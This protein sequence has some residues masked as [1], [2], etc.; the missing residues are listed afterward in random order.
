MRFWYT[1]LFAASLVSCVGTVQAQEKKPGKKPD[2]AVAS[3][4]KGEETKSSPLFLRVDREGKEPRALQVAIAKYEIVS[5]PFQGATVDLIGAVHVGTK[6]YYSDLNQRFR[7]YDSVLYELV[8]DPEVNKPNQRAQG[9]FNPISGLQTGMKEALELSFQLDEVDYSPANFVHADMSPGEF[10]EDMKKRNDG[11]IGMFARM[12]GAGIAVQA[13]KK[14][15]QQQAEMMAA[16]VSKDPIRLRRVMAEQFE[17]MEGQMAG[18]ADKD[19]KSTLVTERNRKA[20]EVLQSELEG[21]KRKL[22]VFYGAAHLNDMH[23]R[24]LKDFQAKP[25]STDWVDAWPLR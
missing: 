4:K 9:G 6:Q 15:Q 11:F 17:S 19:G 23:D 1:V 14:G 7:N 21:G 2:S 16:M 18:L 13:S 12:M 3:D 10:G 24:L 20:F 8:A 22:A 25:I 5:G